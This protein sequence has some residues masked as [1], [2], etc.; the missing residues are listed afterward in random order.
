MWGQISGSSRFSSKE[1]GGGRISRSIHAWLDQLRLPI[2][3]IVVDW[4]GFIKRRSVCICGFA[5][6]KKR[7]YTR[8]LRV[9]DGSHFS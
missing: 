3:K 5:C 8:E 7:P 6:R 9:A 1:D 2:E 4:L